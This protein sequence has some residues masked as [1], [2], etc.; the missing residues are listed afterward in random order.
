MARYSY[1]RNSKGNKAKKTH[2]AA[3]TFCMV[4][5][6]AVSWYALDF[7]GNLPADNGG[8][9]SDLT[10]S[11][12]GMLFDTV[13]GPLGPVTPES[14]PEEPEDQTESGETESK[15]PEE[16]QA[17]TEAT[18]FVMPVVGEVIKPHSPAEPV[19]SE[20]FLDFRIHKGVDI[21]A[22]VDAPV[23]AAGHGIVRAVRSDELLGNVVEIDHGN[24]IV[25]FYYGLA[26]HIMV[27]EGQTVEA[28]QPIG[29]IGTVPTECVDAPHLHLE[30]TKDGELCSPM[31][32]LGLN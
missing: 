9:S 27:E 24:G 7:A 29:T 4:A 19:Y 14:E 32:I 18:F 17:A 12:Q 15:P 11:S 26:E 3:L 10:S 23:S 20:T 21:S 2:F 25:C 30:V 5:L 16:L 13:S 22:A 28:S 6:G 8:A 31:D 1:S